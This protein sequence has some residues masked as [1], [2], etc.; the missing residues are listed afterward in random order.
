MDGSLYDLLSSECHE[1]LD[2]EVENLYSTEDGETSKQAHSSSNDGYLSF[3]SVFRVFLNEVEC[4]CVKID[5]NHFQLGIF[6][7]FSWFMYND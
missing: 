5:V 4:G 3:R 7:S 2:S 6:N 1:I